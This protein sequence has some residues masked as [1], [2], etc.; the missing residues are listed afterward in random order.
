MARRTVA[1][2]LQMYKEDEVEYRRG[3]A[4]EEMSAEIREGEALL[5]LFLH[6]FVAQ[7]VLNFH[8]DGQELDPVAL[9][10]KVLDEGILS[11]RIMKS[12]LNPK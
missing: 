1:D 6:K 8:S 3:Q 9:I 10:A 12:K 2:L 11:C 7:N 4:G 5:N